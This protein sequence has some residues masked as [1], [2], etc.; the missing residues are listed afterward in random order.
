MGPK[1]AEEA[2]ERYGRY[3]LA[4]SSVPIK[5]LN[6]IGISAQN[7]TQFTVDFCTKWMKEY[8]ETTNL[9]F[10]STQEIPAKVCTYVS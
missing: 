9:F 2:E 8:I 7:G 4:K 5:W 3:G 1:I 10:P 6:K